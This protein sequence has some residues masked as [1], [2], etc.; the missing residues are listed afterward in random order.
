MVDNF[1]ANIIQTSCD[2]DLT[3]ISQTDLIFIFLNPGHD[4]P[5]I[6]LTD[7]SYLE[8]NHYLFPQ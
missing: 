8:L 7:K 4:L 3:L 1:Y 6:W 2:H 5:L